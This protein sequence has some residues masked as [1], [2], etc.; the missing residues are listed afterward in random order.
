M[1]LFLWGLCL[2][3]VVTVEKSLLPLEGS[4]PIIHMLSLV[5]ATKQFESLLESSNM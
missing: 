3:G 5:A 1:Y 4:A 2:T